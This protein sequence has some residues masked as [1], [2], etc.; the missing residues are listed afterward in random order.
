VQAFKRL[1]YPVHHDFD[2]YQKTNGFTSN[3]AAA[4]SAKKYGANGYN[5]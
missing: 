5:K 4:N 1:D 3:D 2:Y